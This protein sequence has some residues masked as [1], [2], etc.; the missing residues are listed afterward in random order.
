MIEKVGT[1]KWLAKESQTKKLT[2]RAAVFRKKNSKGESGT[3]H[4][5]TTGLG[6]G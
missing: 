1:A 5:F 6:G 4:A 2:K 3:T